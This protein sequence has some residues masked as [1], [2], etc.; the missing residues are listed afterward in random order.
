MWETSGRSQHETLEDFTARLTAAMD[1]ESNTN[2][3][4]QYR[5]GAIWIPKHII[6]P[7]QYTAL[8]GMGVVNA[9]EAVRGP[10][11]LD[12]NRLSDGDK[13][14]YAGAYA[15]YGVDTGDTTASGSTTSVRSRFFKTAHTPT[16]WPHPRPTVSTVPWRILM[17]ACANRAEEP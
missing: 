17:W 13:A 14:E 11:Y 5:N 9:G 12:A 1:G 8:F 3:N 6:T 7:V 4:V 16:A 2:P 10:G 15:M